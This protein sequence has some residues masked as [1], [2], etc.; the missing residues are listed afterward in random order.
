MEA[1]LRRARPGGDPPSLD[2]SV[3]VVDGER[4][5]ADNSI[6]DRR[7]CE[8]FARVVEERRRLARL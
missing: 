3:S 6:S 1:A 7:M 5:L 2:A 4:V 8:D